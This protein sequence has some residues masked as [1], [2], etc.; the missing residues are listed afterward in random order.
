MTRA[1]L[2]QGRGQNTGREQHSDRGDARHAPSP[3]RRGL[4]VQLCV[5]PCDQ[6]AHPDDRVADCAKQRWRIADGRLRQQGA[7]QK[8]EIPEG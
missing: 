2:Q 1:A 3:V 5:E 8:R 4:V 7:G 6:A